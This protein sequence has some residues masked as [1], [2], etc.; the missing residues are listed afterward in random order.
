M[1]F[2]F[3]CAAIVFASQGEWDLFGIAVALW[4]IAVVVSLIVSRS[5]NN[6]DSRRKK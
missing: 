2:V 4:V 1:M 5:D 6:D 3:L